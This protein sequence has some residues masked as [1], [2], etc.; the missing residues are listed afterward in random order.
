MDK[1]PHFPYNKQILELYLSDPNNQMWIKYTKLQQWKKEI[2]E[3]I[4]GLYRLDTPKGETYYAI[5][6][7]KPI[8]AQYD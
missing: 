1:L 5:L 6:D 3:F 8:L 4:I 7:G 2:N